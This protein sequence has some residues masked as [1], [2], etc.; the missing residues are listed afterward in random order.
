MRS[1]L[2]IIQS[3]FE[4]YSEAREC[5][6]SLLRLKFVACCQ[7][8]RID[9]FYTWEGECVEAKEFRVSFK[10]DKEHIHKVVEYLVANHSYQIPQIIVIP[11][12]ECSLSYLNWCRE[13]LD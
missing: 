12:L 11:T 4:D 13:Q 1:D 9:S 7:I 10:T 2:V 3:T 5:I 8:D 6:N